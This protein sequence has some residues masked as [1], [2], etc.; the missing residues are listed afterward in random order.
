[1]Y[2]HLIPKYTK[3]NNNLLETENMFCLYGDGIICL[4]TEF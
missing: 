4:E 2:K 1:M 3:N